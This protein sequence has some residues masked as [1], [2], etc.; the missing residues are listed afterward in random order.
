MRVFIIWLLMLLI[1]CVILYFALGKLYDFLNVKEE[2]A[3][4]QRVRKEEEYRLNLNHAAL[5]EKKILLER[6]ILAKSN[7]IHD[8][9]EIK[10]LEKELDEVNELINSI[11]K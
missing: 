9:G 7:M 6:E 8:L 2:R 3:A 11:S 1:V 10:H 5:K 4:L